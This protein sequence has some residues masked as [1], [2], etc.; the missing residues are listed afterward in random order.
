MPSPPKTNTELIET[1]R[2]SGIFSAEKLAQ[3]TADAETWPVKPVKAAS[4]LIKQGHLTKFQVQLL[5]QGR[6]KGFRLGS[7]VVLDLLGRGGMGAVYLAEHEDLRR[8]VAV[9]VLVPGTDSDAKLAQDRFLR[10]ARSAAALDHP[11]IVRIHDVGRHTD[12]PYLVMEYV[13][14]DTLQHALDQKGAMPYLEAAEYIAQAAAGLQHAYEKGFVHRDIKPANLI[15][16]AAGVVKILDMGLARN[17]G[18]TDDKLTEQLDHG[19]IVGTADF[20]SPEQ[21]LNTPLDIRADIYSLGATFFALVTGKP[22]FEGNTTQKLLQHQLKDAPDLTELTTDLPDELAMVIARMMAKKPDQRYSTPADVIGALS[23]W[24]QDRHRV[25]AGLSRTRLAGTVDLNMA[26][27][28]ASRGGSSL[29]FSSTALAEAPPGQNSGIQPIENPRSEADTVDEIRAARTSR[30]TP[31]KV[32]PQVRSGPIP[33]VNRTPPSSSSAFLRKHRTLLIVV[34]AVVSIL[35]GG[36]LAY[37]IHGKPSTAPAASPP[38]V[39]Q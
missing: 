32:G 6:Y 4:Y 29:R 10:E 15:R 7:Y 26:L 38:Q 31:S 30:T 21:A 39:S 16:D 8:K 2:K 24:L 12:M 5:L 37:A 11:N 36:L 18:I 1:I 3:I 17:Y 34:G 22:P 13:A 33:S 28:E 19:A 25:L 23:P 9:K 20:I 14:G 35:L 27:Q